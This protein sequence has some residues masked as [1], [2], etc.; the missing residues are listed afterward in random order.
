MTPET[1][2]LHLVGPDGLEHGQLVVGKDIPE[3]QYQKLVDAE[4]GALYA[5]KDLENQITQNVEEQWRAVSSQKRVVKTL[6]RVTSVE[7]R[8]WQEELKKYK[9]GRSVPSCG[10]LG[11][12]Q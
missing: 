6:R 12:S 2:H 5:L 3:E 1:V 4:T 7:R 9:T 11:V 8:K 10:F